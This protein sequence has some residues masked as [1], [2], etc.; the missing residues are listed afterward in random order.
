M[1]AT[2]EEIKQAFIKWNSVECM[3]DE[4][5]EALTVEELANLQ[6]EDLIKFLEQVQNK[7]Q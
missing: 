4:E 3:S 6:T 1:I 7:E 2:N 5:T